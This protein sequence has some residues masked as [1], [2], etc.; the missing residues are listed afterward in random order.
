MRNQAQV[1]L[2]CSCTLG[3][4]VNTQTMGITLLCIG[5]IIFVS[6][7]FIVALSKDGF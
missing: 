5:T 7:A 3:K 6:F 2:K 1:L 4:L